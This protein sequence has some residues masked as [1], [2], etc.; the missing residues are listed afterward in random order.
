MADLMPK[1]IPSSNSLP[2]T[3]PTYNPTGSIPQHNIPTYDVGQVPEQPASLPGGAV[4]NSSTP[5][6]NAS[7]EDAANGVKSNQPNMFKL[8]RGRSKFI[9]IVYIVVPYFFRQNFKN[10]DR[11]DQV[12][13]ATK[14]L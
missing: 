12:N 11:V 8:K 14:N 5:V 10:Y 9:I 4:R 3:V 7:A 2:G 13:I 6:A 1:T